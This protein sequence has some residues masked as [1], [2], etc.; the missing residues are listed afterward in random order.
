MMRFFSPGGLGPLVDLVDNPILKNDIARF[1]ESGKIISAVCHGQAGLLNVILSDKQPMIR[2]KNITSFT[3]DE[4]NIKKHE[5]E[6]V[7]PFLLEDALKNQ[8]AIF[9]NRQPF[10]NYVVTDGNIITGQNPAS[11]SGV[12]KAV[13]KKLNS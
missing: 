13:I 5:L 10:E 7:I 2:G 6:K 8:G 1:Y 4:E 9:S 12:A 11:A 3:K